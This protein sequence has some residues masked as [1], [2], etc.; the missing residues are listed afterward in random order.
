MHGS[1][2]MTLDTLRGREIG[3]SDH[4]EEAEAAAIPPA[5][6]GRLRVEF[7]CLY[8]A[9]PLILAVA[10]PT[11]A[12]FP[13]LFAATAVGLV[14]LAL[15][16]GFRWRE[17]TRGAGSIGWGRVAAFTL[18]TAGAGSAVLAATQPG[19]FLILPRQVPGLMLAIAVLYP[20]LSALPQ[21]ILFRA[22]V[23]PPLRL[24]R[25]PPTRGAQVALNAAVFSAAH[26]LY[27]S[28]IVALMTLAGGLVFAWSYRMRGNFPEAVVAAQPGRHHPLR[29]RARRL[30]LLG[31]RRAAVLTTPPPCR[32][33]ARFR[34]SGRS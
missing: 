15:T 13:G 29:A 31:Q 28:L 23:L 3:G 12:L 11:D 9:F 27:W 20:V 7:L 14:L 34:P 16:P 25:C 2:T 33:G 8:V 5:R 10:L 30:L 1:G 17:L 32:R 22:L 6:R 4:G 21:E 18:V 24:A 19:A 26:L